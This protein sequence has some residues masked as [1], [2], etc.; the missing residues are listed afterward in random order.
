VPLSENDDASPVLKRKVFRDSAFG[1]YRD[2]T[3]GS[4]KIGGSKCKYNDTHVFADGI[5]YKV[6][7]GLWEL[8]TKTRP[9]KTMVTLQHRQAYK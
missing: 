6:T 8:L 7:S 4:L 1:V 5:K 3:D 2:E 9:D